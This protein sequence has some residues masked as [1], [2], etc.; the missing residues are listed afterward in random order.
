MN[1]IKE[2]VMEGVFLFNGSHIH[3]RGSLNLCVLVCKRI[4]G[5]A[6]N[7]CMAVFVGKSMETD[8]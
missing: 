1:H 5:N 4:S 8:Q 2:K 6:E 7:R 3:Y